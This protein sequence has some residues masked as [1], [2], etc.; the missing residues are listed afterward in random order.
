MIPGE[1]LTEKPI[2]LRNACI[3]YLGH[4]PT[5]LDMKIHEATGLGLTEPT[6]FTKIFERGIDPDVD[7]PEHVHWHSEIPSEWPPLETILQYQE[8][9]RNRVV[10]LYTSE[11]VPKDSW[12]GRALWLGFEHEVMHLETLLYMM[13][14]SDKTRPPPDTVRP[15]FEQL[16]A[17]AK[18]NAVPNQWFEIPEQNVKIGLDDPD[19][20]EGPTRYFG[21]DCEKPSYTVKVPSFNAQGRPITNEEYAQ[22][23]VVTKKEQIPASWSVQN[24]RDSANGI[25]HRDHGDSD[26]HKY[27]DGKFVRTMYGPV[28]L[29]YALDWPVSA[30]YDELLGC[31]QYMGGRIPT[32]EETRSIYEYAA[33]VKK[34]EADQALGKKI[35]A[36]NGHLVNE[37]VEETPP[38]NGQPN[39][40]GVTAGPYPSREELFV[41]LEEVN[42]GFKY[43]HPMPVT[44]DG[45]KLAGQ[46]EMG[47]VW[48]WT[49]SV[50]EERK[51]FEPMKLYPAYSADFYDGKH[52]IVLG[53]SWATHPRLAGRK[54]V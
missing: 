30:S 45:H 5:F 33:V 22:Y 11:T 9:V 6:Y 25:D 47:G 26:L 37:G 20:A 54:T 16:A 1:E 28:P 10:N 50:L 23:L 24:K 4:I 39:G 52:N 18:R 34:K 42:V 13:L 38:S 48:E 3:F 21:W 31:A 14:Q 46:A 44:Q 17:K 41:D 43:W 2:K 40:T 35:P 32:M 51:G 8:A 36:V 19:S 15:D 7:N 53:G 27:V 49:S 29:K 12:A